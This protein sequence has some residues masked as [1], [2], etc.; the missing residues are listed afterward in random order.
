VA[1]SARSLGMASLL[2]YPPTGHAAR[3]GPIPPIWFGLTFPESPKTGK[4]EAVT[5]AAVSFC[6]YL[7]QD[8]H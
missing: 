8:T 4:W 2:F 6:T 3:I 1:P 7:S 5:G